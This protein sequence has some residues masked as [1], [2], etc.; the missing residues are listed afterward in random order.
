MEFGHKLRHSVTSGV[1]NSSYSFLS[2][3]LGTT[4]MNA[5]SGTNV[6]LR[7]QNVTGFILQSDLHCRVHNSLYFGSANAT[8]GNV[9][10][11]GADYLGSKYL[12]LR[13][14]GFL[15]LNSPNTI[16][17]GALTS[18][19]DD[20]LKFNET[21]LTDAIDKM[22]LLNPVSYT[23]IISVDQDPETDGFP[24]TGVVAQEVQAIPGLESLV[25]S[26][27]TEVASDGTP[28]LS[29]NYNGLFCHGLQAIKELISKVE[30]LEARVAALESR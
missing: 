21:P 6:E 30:T 11:F 16:Y 20:R 13:A 23:K 2:H 7:I 9:F 12:Q 28:I 25:S 15:Q 26:Q 1:S 5:M 8:G 19:S 29:V 24:E 27:G 10:L 18:G 17:Y 4:L 3:S 14:T 22:K